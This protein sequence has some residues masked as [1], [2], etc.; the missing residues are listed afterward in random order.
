VSEALNKTQHITQH[1]VNMLLN[2]RPGK[3]QAKDIQASTGTAFS[4]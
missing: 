1:D 2:Q 3:L 4:G